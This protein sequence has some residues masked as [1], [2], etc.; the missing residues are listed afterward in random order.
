M[1]GL[2]PSHIFTWNY[3]LDDH[4]LDLCDHCMQ[5]SH[6]QVV[7]IVEPKYK[8][9]EVLLDRIGHEYELQP[10]RFV[11]FGGCGEILYPFPP[12]G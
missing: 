5:H 9:E 11:R 10:L 6:H 4:F 12:C 2:C 3:Y 8:G 1:S 7:N